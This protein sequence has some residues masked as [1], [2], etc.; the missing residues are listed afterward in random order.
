MVCHKLDGVQE[1]MSKHKKIGD[2]GEKIEICNCSVPN[3][4]SSKFV[5]CNPQEVDEL[6]LEESP[7]LAVSSAK[8]MTK[9]EWRKEGFYFTDNMWDMAAIVNGNL[10]Q[11]GLELVEVYMPY[12][13]EIG[14]KIQKK[15]V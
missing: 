10:K 14:F 12:E 11:F 2:P 13:D 15:G 4:F 5:I 3:P 9:D 8:S 6:F 1:I 7:R